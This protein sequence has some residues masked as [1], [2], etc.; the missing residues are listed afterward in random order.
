MYITNYT[1]IQKTH[2]APFDVFLS[3]RKNCLW[4]HLLTLK[5]LIHT[6]KI[7]ANWSFKNKIITEQHEFLLGI[8]LSHIFVLSSI[9]VIFKIPLSLY[10]WD[11][12]FFF[13][14]WNEWTIM[15]I[16]VSNFHVTVLGS[17]DWNTFGTYFFTWKQKII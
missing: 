9:Q 1:H 4:C 15:K 16:N 3:L 2:R 5:K 14:E 11:L 10:C 6:V 17:L 8:K 13:L 12:Q 7:I